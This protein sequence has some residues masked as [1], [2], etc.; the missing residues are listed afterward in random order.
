MLCIY[1]LVLCAYP[2]LGCGYSSHYENTS[3]VLGVRAVDTGIVGIY[4]AHMLASIPGECI[5][6]VELRDGADRTVERIES[7]EDIRNKKVFTVKMNICQDSNDTFQVIIK[8]KLSG[9]ELFSIASEKK[10]YKVGKF[11]QDTAAPVYC[12]Q[13]SKLR[14]YPLLKL[15][16]PSIYSACITSVDTCECDYCTQCDTVP[17]TGPGHTP[18]LVERYTGYKEYHTVRLYYYWIHPSQSDTEDS[19]QIKIQ[20]QQGHCDQVFTQD[21]VLTE[22][23]DR[24]DNESYKTNKMIYNGKNDD[25]LKVYALKADESDC[26]ENEKHLSYVLI[27]VSAGVI[28]LLL[29]GITILLYICKVKHCC[30]RKE[31]REN[32]EPITDNGPVGSQDSENNDVGIT[33]EAWKTVI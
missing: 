8:A 29:V 23:A 18:L 1:L 5:Q 25:Y 33:K 12:Y 24:R 26:P 6:Q 32:E 27:A 15:L 4:W 22:D 2:A 31:S 10:S 7:V 28:I 9:G 3:R 30:P 14:L 13:G 21:T 16:E 11:F 17:N 20:L 19:V